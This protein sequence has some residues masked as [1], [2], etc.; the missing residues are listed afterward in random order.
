MAALAPRE[1]A[2]DF[3]LPDEN[4]QP[5]SLSEAL[6]K[7]PVLLTFFKTSCPT[8]QYALPFFDRLASKLDGKPVTIWAVSQNSTKNTTAFNQEFDIHM[9]ELFDSEDEGFPVSDA[10]GLTNVPTSFFIERDGTISLT[11]VGWDK[12]EFEQISKYLGD[13]ASLPEL[14]AFEPGEDVLD[15]KAG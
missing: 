3:E 7:G 2:P 4:E 13:A 5:R 15:F 1:K 6:Q 11:S 12:T 8:C 14:T 10:Y 9:P